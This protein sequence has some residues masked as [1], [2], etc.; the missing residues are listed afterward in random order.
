MPATNTRMPCRRRTYI[1]IILP[2]MLF[3][4][5]LPVACVLL[6]V[7]ASAQPVFDHA[8][9]VGDARTYTVYVVPDLGTLEQPQNG[10]DQVWDYSSLTAFQAGTLVAGPAAGTPHADQYPE[11]NWSWKLSSGSNPDQYV[12]LR[13]TSAGIETVANSVPSNP[14]H[15]VDGRGLIQFPFPYESSYTDT[16]TLNGTQA[17]AE[18]AYTGY[19]NLT[20]GQGIMNNLAKVVSD[21]G[22]VNLWQMNPLFP[23]ATPSGNGLLIFLPQGGMG[24][25]EMRTTDMIAYPIPCADRITIDAP[26]RA[27]WRLF[28][29]G[30][31]QVAEGHFNGPGPQVVDTQALAPGTY[32]L[33]TDGD[34]PGLARFLKW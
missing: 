18:I 13:V 4:P 7:T 19:G 20:I 29:L 33:L 28:S 10:P 6:S 8:N 17:T 2:N 21:Q 11:A 15:F 12:Y 31:G 1:R 27:N 32:F 16:W 3:R 30:G 26:F 22:D 9:W 5:T 23:V 25:A 14:N 24:I 34:T